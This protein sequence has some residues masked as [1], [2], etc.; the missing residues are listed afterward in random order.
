MKPIR[1][2]GDLIDVLAIYSRDMPLHFTADREPVRLATDVQINQAF[3]LDPAKA[4]RLEISF[5][6]Q[7]KESA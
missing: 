5:F 1:T 6:S 4:P 7:K 3:F 2:V